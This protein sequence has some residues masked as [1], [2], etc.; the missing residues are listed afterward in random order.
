M[1]A[2][3]IEGCGRMHGNGLFCCIDHWYELPIPMRDE[4]WRAYKEEGVFS[5]EYMQ[6]AE[7]AEAFLENRDARDMAGTFG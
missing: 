5:D 3:R 4:V 6:A 2:C 7:N 1:R